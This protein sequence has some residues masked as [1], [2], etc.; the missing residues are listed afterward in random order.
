MK[1]YIYTG[2]VYHYRLHPQTHG[3]KYGL[4]MMYIDLHELPALFR[5]FLCWSDST[6]ALAWFRRKDHMGD[7]RQTLSG[8]V[9]DFI[10][11]ESGKIHQGPIRLLTHLRYLGY[12]MN[13]VSFYYCW[14]DTDSNLEFIVAEVHNTPWGE[15]HC[16]L[17]NCETAQSQGDVFTFNFNKEFHV[18]PFMGMQQE[19]KWSLS[20]PGSE[21]R[22]N[23]D[24]FEADN[25]IFNAGMRLERK[26]ITSTYMAKVLLNYPFMTASVIGRIYWQAMKLWLKKIPF[27]PHPKQLKQETSL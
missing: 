14:D 19:Y 12:C 5:P 21:L 4:F 13:P 24:S 16:Y 1:S 15:T 8:S 20:T 3:F 25:K 7:P 18:S 17:L 9:R 11:K 23:M 22:V 27:Y 2:D 6:P 26:P 10:H